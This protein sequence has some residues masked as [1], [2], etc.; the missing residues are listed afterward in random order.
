ML[1]LSRDNHRD[2]S[3]YTYIHVSTDTDHMEALKVAVTIAMQGKEQAESK[4]CIVS[5]KT[6]SS[7]MV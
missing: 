3:R 1:D 7:P 4:V 6:S 5:W 2:I